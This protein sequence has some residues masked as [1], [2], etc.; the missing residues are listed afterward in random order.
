MNGRTVTKEQMRTLALQGLNFAGPSRD[1]V[2][3]DIDRHRQRVTVKC[4][5]HIVLAMSRMELLNRAR[6]FGSV[7]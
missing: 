7:Q 4:N 2:T 6:L 1:W 3:V 5:G